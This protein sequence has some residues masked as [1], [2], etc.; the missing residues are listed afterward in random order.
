MKLTDI[1]EEKENSICL[2]ILNGK[3][4]YVPFKYEDELNNDIIEEDN[5][6]H[7]TEYALN[8]C[9][10][11][12][13]ENDLPLINYHND[14][15]KEMHFAFIKNMSLNKKY[16]PL[17][18]NIED[19]R[20]IFP[21]NKYRV[22]LEGKNIIETFVNQCSGIKVDEFVIETDKLKSIGF[23]IHNS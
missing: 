5:S 16:L 1:I 14:N 19:L 10:R 7:Y 6:T 8:E 15:T 20:K 22:C 3:C 21:S 9:N 13:K 4:F 2:D 17:F 23:N 11:I 18:S 12:R